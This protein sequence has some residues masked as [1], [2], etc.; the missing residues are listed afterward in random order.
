VTVYAEHRRGAHIARWLA[1]IDEAYAEMERRIDA[2]SHCIRLESYLMRE[3][4]P[5]TWLRDALQRA[6]ARGVAVKLLLDAFG[7]EGVRREFL[8]PLRDAGVVIAVFNPQRWLRRS[9]RNHRKLL[10]CD[11]EHAVLGG[12][13][14][15]PEYAGDGVTRGWCDTAVYVGGPVVR[16]LEASFDAM[17]ALARF[18]PR[19]FRRFRAAARNSFAEA[20]PVDAADAAVRLLLTGPGT[21]GRYLRHQLGHDLRRARNLD[22]ASAYFL[23]SRRL[24]RLLYLG[25][26]RGRVRLL[27]AGR[28]DVPLALL[29]AERYYDRLISRQVQIFEYQPQI[30]HAKLVLA[31]DVAYVGS[32]NLDWRSLHINYELLL[33]FEWPELVA[34]A[35]H[36]YEQALIQAQVLDHARLRA[37][38]GLW[39]RLGSLLSYFLLARLDALVARR[40]FRTIS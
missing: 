16:Q 19:R 12:F 18:T 33:R 24:R 4:G 8:Q 30:L 10:A 40:G 34:D 17:F 3:E 7:T 36:W 14:I 11:G 25:A 5:A 35:R 6:R 9:F 23:P 2:A 37:R 1:T 26:Q 38:R 20:A 28:S 21:R 13:N 29:A 32:A 31:D 27:L 22:I 15:A 39:R